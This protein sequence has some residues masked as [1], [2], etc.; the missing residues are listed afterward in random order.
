MNINKSIDRINIF[1]LTEHE[2]EYS[3]RLA[4]Q[5]FLL[6]VFF[7]N[8]I[9]YNKIIVTLTEIDNLMEGPDEAIEI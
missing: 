2:R 7:D 5:N 1:Y 6:F 3:N 4:S 8:N 9:H